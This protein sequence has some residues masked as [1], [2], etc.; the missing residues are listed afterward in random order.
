MEIMKVLEDLPVLAAF[1]WPLGCSRRS[2]RRRATAARRGGTGPSRC[3]GGLAPSVGNNTNLAR[4]PQAA[5]SAT[6]QE[7]DFLDAIRG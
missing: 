7:D 1:D 4:S 5:S 6:S 2:S 3:K